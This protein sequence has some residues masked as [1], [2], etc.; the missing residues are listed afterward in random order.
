VAGCRPLR[1]RLLPRRARGE[2]RCDDGNPC[3][4]GDV[5][6]DGACNPGEIEP[7]QTA[8]SDD[9]NPCT[10]DICDA[11]ARCIHVPGH[12]G[13]LC[14]AAAG[15]C[16]VAEYCGGMVGY[17]PLDDF[18]PA[19]QLC[20]AAAGVCD[21]A[22]HCTGAG[23]QCPGDGKLTGICRASAGA[24]DVAEQCDGQHDDCPVDLKSTDVCRASSGVCDLEERCDGTSNAC[25]ADVVA[26]ATVQCRAAGGVCDVAE[27]CTGGGLSAT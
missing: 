15:P 2:P 25:P 7:A 14:R 8:C 4:F 10:E 9:G 22:E 1:V 11:S 6:L 3:T 27:F 12:Q 13:D 23:P 17:C 21:A 24:C 26:P 18:E 5:C 20:R 19:G 16:D